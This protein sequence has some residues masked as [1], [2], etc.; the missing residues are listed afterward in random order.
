MIPSSRVAIVK[1]ATGKFLVWVDGVPIRRPHENQQAE[2][3]SK[4]NARRAAKMFCERDR[5]GFLI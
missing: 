1:L 2:F 3:S 5:R 4:R